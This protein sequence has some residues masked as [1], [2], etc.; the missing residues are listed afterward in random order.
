M[1]RFF[2]FLK[3]RKF[4]TS[5]LAKK[6]LLELFKLFFYKI[7][8]TKKKFQ[9]SRRVKFSVLQINFLFFSTNYKTILNF[10]KIN[11]FHFFF[12]IKK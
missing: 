3:I 5:K 11:F 7:S 6:I 1:T 12:N 2:G 4:F 8:K 10:L 9:K